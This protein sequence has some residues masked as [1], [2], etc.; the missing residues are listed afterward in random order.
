[1][2]DGGD[3]EIGGRFGEARRQ[4][5]ADCGANEVSIDGLCTPPEGSAGT[6]VSAYAHMRGGLHEVERAARFLQL[7][8]AGAGLDDPAPTAAAVFEAAEAGPLT[9]AAALWRDLQGIMRLVVEEGSD[10][11]AAGPKVRSLV[12]NACG[13]EDFEALETAVAET[14]SRAAAGIDTLLSR[15]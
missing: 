9:Q 8:N 12:A 13:H 4:I 3:S 2:F 5:L 14:A 1:M 7:T 11:A 10:A 15:A 6:G